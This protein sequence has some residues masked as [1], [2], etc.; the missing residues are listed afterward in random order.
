MHK[1]DE[2]AP[3]VAML[4]GGI[5]ALTGQGSDFLQ[6]RLE[7]DAVFVD[8]PQPEEVPMAPLDRIICAAVAVV[9][10]VVRQVGFEVD[11][12]WHAPF[13]NDAALPRITCRLR[14][15]MLPVTQHVDSEKV[16]P[17]IY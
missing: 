12:S 8:R 11:M 2:V 15:F 13:Y 3:V 16:L 17:C 14:H 1:A 5:G 6:D 10:L 4:D 9:E 7:L